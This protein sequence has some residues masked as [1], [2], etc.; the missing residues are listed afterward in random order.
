MKKLLSGLFASMMFLVACGEEGEN[1]GAENGSDNNNSSSNVAAENEDN[2]SSNDSENNTANEE[3]ETAEADREDWPETLRF[4]DT[5]VEGMEELQREFGPFKETLEDVLDIEVEFFAVTDRI[6]GATALEYDQ[7][8]MLLAGP[9]EY[10]QI[11]N[12]VPES[13]PFVGIERSEYHAAFIV[14]EDSE[15]ETLDDIVG[16]SIAMK[17]AGSTSG[18]I[19]PSSILIEEGYDLDND[20]DIQLLDSVRIEAFKNHEVDVLATGIKDY[21]EM[22]EEDG[23]GHYRLLHEGPPLPNDAFVASPEL[24]EDF[25]EE[26]QTLMLENQEDILDSILV[27]GENDKY[28]EAGFVSAE[29]ADYDSM[30]RAYETLGLDFE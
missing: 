12:T 13:Y 27:T 5:G 14:H 24:P 25:V 1:A 8:D 15:Y 29:D 28:I 18:H 19:G 21:Y 26:V 20:F 30:R 16:T 7:V 22:V 3:N 23:E 9:S 10:V 4:A 11:N 6:I 2:N 17:D